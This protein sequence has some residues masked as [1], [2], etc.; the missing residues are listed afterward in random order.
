MLGIVVIYF[1]IKLQHL[2]NFLYVTAICKLGDFSTMILKWKINEC[3]QY[4]N[5]FQRFRKHFKHTKCYKAFQSTFVYRQPLSSHLWQLMASS[6]L[7]KRLVAACFARINENWLVLFKG[8][9]F[10]IL[11]IGAARVT[12]SVFCN[13]HV[14]FF[15][16]VYSTDSSKK[17]KSAAQFMKNSQR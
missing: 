8:S 2:K 9:A 6:D 10:W 1:W 13:Y 14:C 16:F 12:S 15:I 5:I 11:V 4:E 7:W 17:N 3:W